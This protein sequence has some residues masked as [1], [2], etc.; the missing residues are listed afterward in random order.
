M[1]IVVGTE[2]KKLDTLLSKKFGQA[3]YYILYDTDNKGYEIIENIDPEDRH[4]PLQ[5]LVRRGADAFIVSYIGPH[6]F[7]V[8]HSANK[9][10]FHA[11]NI[12]VL[13]AI[14]KLLNNELEELKEPNVK[15]SMAH[16]H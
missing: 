4:V 7:E 14:E 13:S 16:H 11:K 10:V 5:E 15:K 9:K 6:A 8:L 12:S 2:E 3:K 1:K